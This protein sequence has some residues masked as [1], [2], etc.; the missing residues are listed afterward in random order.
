MSTLAK[1]TYPFCTYCASKHATLAL[2]RGLRAQLKEH[3]VNVLNLPWSNR[4]RYDRIARPP[5][6]VSP[7]KVSQKI[8]TAIE[9]GLNLKFM[10]KMTL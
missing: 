5:P 6:K 7:L 8:M 1:V 10:L 9:N 2:T 3:N 4:Y